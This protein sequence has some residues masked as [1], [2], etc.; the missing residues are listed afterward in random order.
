MAAGAALGDGDD[1]RQPC[2]ED[3]AGGKEVGRECVPRTRRSMKRSEMM[4]R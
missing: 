2:L 4:R 3:G 1:A